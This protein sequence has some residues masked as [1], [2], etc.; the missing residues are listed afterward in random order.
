MRT[1][2]LFMWSLLR[3][4]P[5]GGASPPGPRSGR[6]QV[7]SRTV[8]EDAPAA[9]P[10]DAAHCRPPGIANAHSPAASNGSVAPPHRV[11]GS[12]CWHHLLNMH[13]KCNFR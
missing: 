2:V 8:A 7:T 11:T 13:L 4:V 3:D 9:A 1:T 12:T 10:D 6:H 5:K